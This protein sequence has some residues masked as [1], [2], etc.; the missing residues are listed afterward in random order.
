MKTRS[1]R[2]AAAAASVLALM[3]GIVKAARVVP[4]DADQIPEHAGAVT[5]LPH[6]TAGMIFAGNRDFGHTIRAALC[7]PQDFDVE[8][9]AVDALILEHRSGAIAAKCLEPAL[10]VAQ[11]AHRQPL[12]APVEETA[13]R[14][15]QTLRCSALARFRKRRAIRSR[16]PRR[17]RAPPRSDPRPQSAATGRRQRTRHSAP[18]TPG[19]PDAPNSPCPGCGRCR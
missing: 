6:G 11:A 14:L 9:K 3:V 10:G 4:A 19:R 8:R 7:D 18:V 17:F 16:R 13:E 1:T 2:A 5:K 12:D 15:T